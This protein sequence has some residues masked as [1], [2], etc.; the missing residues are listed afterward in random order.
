M[1]VDLHVDVSK[2]LVAIPN[3]V[4]KPALY[5][6]VG[7]GHMQVR[8]TLRVGKT[9]WDCKLDYARSAGASNT[10]SCT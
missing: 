9:S 3:P 7:T 2:I 4:N 8:L 10:E 1:C 6:A 5:V